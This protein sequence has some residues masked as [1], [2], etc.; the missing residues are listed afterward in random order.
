MKYIIT[1]KLEFKSGRYRQI[2]WEE[3]NPTFVSGEGEDATR[4]PATK[5]ELQ[6]TI[7]N[8]LIT[9]M[10]KSG[11]RIF[12]DDTTNKTIIVRFEDV[13]EVDV[14]VEEVTE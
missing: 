9:I 5:K 10:D 14:S 1:L 6:N 12:E 4:R 13:S 8:S 11:I 3:N 7:N 2:T